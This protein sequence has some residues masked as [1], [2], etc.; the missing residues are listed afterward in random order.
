MALR[1]QTEISNAGRATQ[2]VRGRLLG[3][4]LVNATG[5]PGAAGRL[6]QRLCPCLA[7]CPLTQDRPR[8]PRVSGPAVQVEGG[9]SVAAATSAAA[10]A[11]DNQQGDHTSGDDQDCNG[12]PNL[13]LS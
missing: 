7:Y 1:H 6:Q 4:A 12:E 3:R 11:V 5:T 9:E 13:E 2:F 10:A 8:P